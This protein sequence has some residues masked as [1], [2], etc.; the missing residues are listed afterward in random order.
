LKRNLRKAF[1]MGY[2]I[3]EGSCIYHI[4]ERRLAHQSQ[5][6]AT[7]RMR[8]A[9]RISVQQQPLCLAGLRFLLWPLRGIGEANMAETDQQYRQCQCQDGAG[10]REH[11]QVVHGL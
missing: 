10:H 7:E 5:R 9:Q 3:L 4:S 11:A 6:R 1:C 2:F 8:K